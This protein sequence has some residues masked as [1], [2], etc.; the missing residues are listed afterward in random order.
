ME[1][2]YGIIIADNARNIS[3]ETAV[4]DLDT[5]SGNFTTLVCLFQVILLWRKYHQPM[6]ANLWGVWP[7]VTCSSRYYQVL[8]GSMHCCLHSDVYTGTDDP[9]V[10]AVSVDFATFLVWS[11]YLL[12]CAIQVKISFYSFGLHLHTILH[13]WYVW[14]IIWLYV[15]GK[16]SLL[17]GAGFVIFI[18]FFDETGLFCRFRDF[19]K[20]VEQGNETPLCTASGDCEVAM[21]HF[22]SCH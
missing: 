14:F 16:I 6:P 7:Q 5:G 11:M 22:A 13:W 2:R 4:P 18:G 19:L 8:C 12:L 9:K 17:F 10:Q 3:S 21:P 15:I 20:S 1:F